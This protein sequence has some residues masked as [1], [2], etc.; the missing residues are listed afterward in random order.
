MDMEA[1]VLQQELMAGREERADLRARIYLLEKEKSNADLMLA[2]R[3]S[4]EQVLRGHIRHLQEELGQAERRGVGAHLMGHL[5]QGSSSSSEAS[6][7]AQLR[8]RVD[9]LTEAVD[10]MARNGEQ[11]Q[12]Q[13]QELIEDLKRANR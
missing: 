5:M 1:A 4:L 8:A 6:A 3:V 9:T 12:K 13:A 10:Q 11:R 2:D 7:E